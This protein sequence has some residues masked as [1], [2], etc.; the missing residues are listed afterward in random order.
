MTTTT[1]NK[2]LQNDLTHLLDHHAHISESWAECGESAEAIAHR[3]APINQRIREVKKQLENRH[4]RLTWG[5]SRE[6]YCK[7]S[8][9]GTV[10]RKYAH[11]SR[12]GKL[13]IQEWIGGNAA[14]WVP[15]PFT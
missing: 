1:T 13:R 15:A 14:K 10:V 7:K 11:L 9:F 8:E 2:Q 4:Y 3:L 5:D 6:V 12:V